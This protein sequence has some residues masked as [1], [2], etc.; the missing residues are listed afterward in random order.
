MSVSTRDIVEATGMISVVVG[1][2]LVAYQINQATSIASAQARA[3]YSAGWRSVDSTRQSE[4]FAEV[5]AK[6]IYYPNELTPGE[7]LE[8][9]LTTSVSWTK[10]SPPKLT[11]R[12]EFEPP[13]AG[14]RRLLGAIVFWKRVFAFWWNLSKE[15]YARSEG[16]QFVA[17]IDAAMEAAESDGQKRLINALQEA[18]S[19]SPISWFRLMAVAASA[20]PSGR[21]LDEPL[22]A[23]ACS[24]R[25]PCI[26]RISS[27]VTPPPQRDDF[28]AA[29]RR[30]DTHRHGAASAP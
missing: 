8:W 13:L 1:L 19:S 10:Y 7:I 6:S 9:M 27:A 28:E 16:E 30:R 2:L 3:E 15:G 5:L 14:N 18:T 20:D 11:G 12:Q 17:T 23:R 29:D 21:A 26:S 4:N 22:S 25:S 24:G